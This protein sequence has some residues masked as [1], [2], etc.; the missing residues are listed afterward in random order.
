[1]IINRDNC[2][3]GVTM[4]AMMILLSVITLDVTVII[5]IT[6]E[7]VINSNNNSHIIIFTLNVSISLILGAISTTINTNVIIKDS[8]AISMII[9]YLPSVFLSPLQLSLF[10]NNHY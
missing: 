5:L 6:V 3:N 10:C 1:M 2:R 8:T 4:T 7:I 9:L